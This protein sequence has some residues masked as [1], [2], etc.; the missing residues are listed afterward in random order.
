M[1]CCTQLACQIVCL[2]CN[3]ETEH[4]MTY[5]NLKASM[6]CLVSCV[7]AAFMMEACV[8]AV[9]VGPIP[10]TQSSFIHLFDTGSVL[11]VLDNTHKLT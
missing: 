1:C 2:C 6:V 10:A 3:V 9:P 11:W 7:C 8:A 4:G 5:T